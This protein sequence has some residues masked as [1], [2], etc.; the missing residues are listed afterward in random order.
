[1]PV[2]LKEEKIILPLRAKLYR[3]AKQEKSQRKS[4]LYGKRVYQQIKEEGLID[5]GNL[6]Y[7]VNALR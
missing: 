7:P 6:R 1:M 2:R 4:K 5:L 3:K